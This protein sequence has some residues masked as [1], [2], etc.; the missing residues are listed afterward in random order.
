MADTLCAH[1]RKLCSECCH[2]TDA[3]KRAYDI[4]RGYTAFVQYEELVRS[5]VAIRLSDGSSDGTLYGSKQDA[6]RHQ[7]AG[8][9]TC[10]YFN[11]RSAP[12]GFATIKEA[13]VWLE[14]HRQAYDSGFRLPDPDDPGGGPELIMPTPKEVLMPQLRELIQPW[15]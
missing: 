6:V 7:G 13:A 11:Y 8:E 12:N 4:V 2:V 10:A 1:G 5:W 15:G 14:Y 9:M 3:A